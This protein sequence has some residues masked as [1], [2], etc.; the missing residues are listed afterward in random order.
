[1][2]PQDLYCVEW[3]LRRLVAEVRSF[4]GVSFPENFETST[5]QGPCET[6][7]CQ[8]AENAP[9][10]I[11][12]R[13]QH[14]ALASSLT[15]GEVCDK[16]HGSS[17]PVLHAIQLLDGSHDRIN[18][19]KKQSPVRGL[20]E[21]SSVFFPLTASSCSFSPRNGR[22]LRNGSLGSVSRTLRL[23]VLVCNARAMIIG[24]RQRG[25]CKSTVWLE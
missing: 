13:S 24:T 11:L 22:G 25:C 21:Y 17:S 15:T 2:G 5:L 9:S 10:P 23:T 18:K 16:E 3:Q 4:F 1:V 7:A 20:P 12:S 14:M 19:A 8:G 6:P